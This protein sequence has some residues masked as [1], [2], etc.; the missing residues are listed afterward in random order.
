MS[1]NQ[2]RDYVT[3]VSFNLQLSRAMISELAEIANLADFAI[4]DRRYDSGPAGRIRQLS[5]AANGA[6]R[7]SVGTQRALE[8]RGL[9]YAPEPQWPGLLQPTEAGAL[10]IDLLRLAGLIV[11]VAIEEKEPAK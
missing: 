10:V 6:V 1:S 8:S 7:D 4:K 5:I 9:V 2:F 3:S 11:D